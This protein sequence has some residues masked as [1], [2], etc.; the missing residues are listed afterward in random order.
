MT[1]FV[2]ALAHWL[3][4]LNLLPADIIDE[5]RLS[6]AGRAEQDRGASGAQA[7]PQRIHA[8][9][10][11]AAN[12]E[13]G[14]ARDALVDR[15]DCTRNVIAQVSF[16]EQ[17]SRFGPAFMR[18]REITLDPPQIQLPRK[19]GDNKCVVDVRG[20]DL[21]FGSITSSSPREPCS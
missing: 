14:H 18:E 12:R 7:R 9:T 20:Q 8:L 10:S 1:A 19:P 21:F 4:G 17:H 3:N 13:D 6:D 15:C 16:C 11:D 2:V 5:S